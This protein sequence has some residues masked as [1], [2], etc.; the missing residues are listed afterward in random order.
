MLAAWKNFYLVLQHDIAKNEQ[1]LV[2][3]NA[4]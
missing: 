2:S 3:Q 1:F 4:I